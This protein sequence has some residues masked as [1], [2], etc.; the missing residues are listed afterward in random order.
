MIRQRSQAADD[1]RTAGV[2]TVFSPLL[3]FRHVIRGSELVMAEI[4]V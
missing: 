1:G 4:R 2:L 3:R